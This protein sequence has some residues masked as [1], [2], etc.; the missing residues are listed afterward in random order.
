VA[1]IQAAAATD[2]A[3]LTAAIGNVLDSDV[4]PAFS[5]NRIPDRSL[6]VGASG[7]ATDD[8][9]EAGT[10]RIVPPAGNGQPWS[11][12]LDMSVTDVQVAGG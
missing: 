2:T 6:I 12:A 5:E 9:I 1:A 11:I 4:A 8:E 7:P 10:F 3:T